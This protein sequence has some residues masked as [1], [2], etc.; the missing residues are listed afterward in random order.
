MVRVLGWVNSSNENNALCDT[1][2]HAQD[3]KYADNLCWWWCRTE[4]SVL[5]SSG[6]QADI[7]A[8]QK[9]LDA[10]HQVGHHQ[11]AEAKR[12]MKD[13]EE[14]RVLLFYVL[15]MWAY[16][17]HHK[18]KLR[19]NFLGVCR[20]TNTSIASKW[21]ARQ[22]HNFYQTLF[23]TNDSSPTTHSMFLVA[24]TMKVLTLFCPPAYIS[25]NDPWY[26]CRLG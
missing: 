11:A 24:W 16:W 4:K 20:F 19:D 23:T 3:F 2:I 17:R 7:R 25:L 14:I 21:A 15:P 1:K 10:R 6:F 22:W 12:V 9:N 26:D 5:A 18:I 13:G 8:L